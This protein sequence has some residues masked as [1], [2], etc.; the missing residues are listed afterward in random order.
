VMCKAISIFVILPSCSISKPQLFPN[1]GRIEMSPR[2]P[3][4]FLAPLESMT[5]PGGDYGTGNMMETHGSCSY[6]C[7]QWPFRPCTMQTRWAWATCIHPY[8]QNP[9]PLDFNGQKMKH[10]N[11]PS[12]ASVPDGCNRCDDECARREGRRGKD[13]Y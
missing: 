3:P 10:L 1:Y 2:A 9:P 6:V 12:C 8:P 7:N 11:Y 13:D 4:P 5:F